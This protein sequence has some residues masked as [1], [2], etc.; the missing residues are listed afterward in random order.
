ML[1]VWKFQESPNQLWNGWGSSCLKDLCIKRVLKCK[2]IIKFV[3][4]VNE[5]CAI[6]LLQAGMQANT[7]ASG[8]DC[9]GDITSFTKNC[10]SKSFF[11][12]QGSKDTFYLIFVPVI[13]RGI[14]GKHPICENNTYVCFHQ[15]H[16][17]ENELL[18]AFAFFL[19]S[20]LS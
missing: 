9:T 12:S 8:I 5:T 2:L 6:T 19:Q 10:T 13:R 1:W 18:L 15:R 17:Q 16:N 7:F 11:F 3:R 20:V 14:S 4:L